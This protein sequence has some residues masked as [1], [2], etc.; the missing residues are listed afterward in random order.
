VA[1]RE[2]RATPPVRVVVEATDEVTRAGIVSCL[3]A[4]GEMTVAPSRAGADVVV[5]AAEGITPGVTGVLRHISRDGAL[6]IVLVVDEIAAADLP[7][8]AGCRV[9]AVLP[10]AMATARRLCEGVRAA[11]SHVSRPPAESARELARQFDQLR[12][13][14]RFD[15]REKQVLRLMAEGLDPAEI[16]ARLGYAERTIGNIVHGVTGRLRL[17]NRTHAVAYAMRAGVI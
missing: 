2:S 14:V 9:V 1:D 17:R 10:R 13:D 5:L 3:R 8:M 6:P 12:A 7:G 15:E 11:A 4:D 16:G